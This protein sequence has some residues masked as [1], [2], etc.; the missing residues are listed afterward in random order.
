MTFLWLL[1][2]PERLEK[3]SLIESESAEVN[4]LIRCS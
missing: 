4:S 3:M 2:I 1:F